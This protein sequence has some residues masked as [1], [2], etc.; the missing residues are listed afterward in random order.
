MGS[1]L[2]PGSWGHSKPGF[3]TTQRMTKRMEM[4]QGMEQL[5]TK[6]GNRLRWILMTMSSSIRVTC[7]LTRTETWERQKTLS[8]PVRESLGAHLARH[9][10]RKETSSKVSGKNSQTY[11]ASSR[12]KKRSQGQQSIALLKLSTSWQHTVSRST[13]V[14]TLSEQF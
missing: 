2:A 11:S 3:S 4:C 13:P 10:R 7:C 6:D 14:A 12:S 8:S 9:K 1:T 5:V